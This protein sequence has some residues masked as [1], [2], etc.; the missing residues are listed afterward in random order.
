MALK[1]WA[2]ALTS[3]KSK[4]YSQRLRVYNSLS[5]S[6][7]VFSVN[8]EVHEVSRWHENIEHLPWHQRKV[9]CTPKDCQK[10]QRALWSVMTWL[11]LMKNSSHNMS[12][13]VMRKKD[14]KNFHCSILFKNIT[15]KK[16]NIRQIIK[17][18]SYLA[19]KY[20]N[21]NSK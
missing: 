7:I 1:Y 9:K 10:W 6:L 13:S 18:K 17:D 20:V 8:F 11:F 19:P 5:P 16:Q 12:V 3:K 2:F 15:D 21:S 14:Q 4:M